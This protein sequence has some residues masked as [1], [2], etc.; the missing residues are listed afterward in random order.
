MILTYTC[1][2]VSVIWFSMIQ[3]TMLH[4][5]IQRHCKNRQFIFLLL[6][7]ENNCIERKWYSFLICELFLLSHWVIQKYIPSEF[8][9]KYIIIK[10]FFSL[11]LLNNTKSNPYRITVNN[12]NWTDINW[13]QSNCFKNTKCTAVNKSENRLKKSQTE[14]D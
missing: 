11:V 6:C 7:Y 2:C 8:Y 9:L 13:L 5:F 14:I 1:I 4:K 12:Y 3:S 10:Y